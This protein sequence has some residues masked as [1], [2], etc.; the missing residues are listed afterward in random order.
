MTH[1]E[2]GKAL[3]RHFVRGLA[4]DQAKAFH[5]HLEDCVPCRARYEA[6]ALL[7]P[8]DRKMLS[9]VERG[10]RGLGF[11]NGKAKAP[12]AVR[13]WG[14]L[15][16][17]VA[18]AAALVLFLLPARRGDSDASMF[19]SRGA[20]TEAAFGLWIFQN[21]PTAPTLLKQQMKAD[22]ELAFA[23]VNPTPKPFLAIF[24]TDEQHR[25]YWYHPG[26]RAGEAPPQSI[27]TVRGTKIQEL[28]ESIRH[29]FQ[30]RHLVISAVL[31]EHPL[32]VQAIETALARGVPLSTVDASAVVV[33]KREVEISP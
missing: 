7:A 2:A 10:A 19:A 28:K 4:V 1:E 9:P 14:P 20:G 13:L 18:C 8:L 21:G 11:A 17:A 26:W 24:A 30:G 6:Y 31:S 23:Y 5:L 3:E 25:V 29:T 12:S 33:A 27:P 15:G 16:L 22:D 32:G